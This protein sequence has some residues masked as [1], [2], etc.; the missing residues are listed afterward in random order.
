MNLKDRTERLYHISG[1]KLKFIKG[2]TDYRCCDKILFK[3][4]NRWKN[5][6]I[7]SV[8]IVD[9]SLEFTICKIVNNKSEYIYKIIEKDIRKPKNEEEWKEGETKEESKEEEKEERKE[10]E[11]MDE[12]KVEEKSRIFDV[13]EDVEAYLMYKGKEQWVK[14]KVHEYNPDNN[15]Y[16][17]QF[18]SVIRY[19]VDANLVREIKS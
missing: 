2:T 11:K 14:T 19:N 4:D 8:N 12:K 1:E 15:C 7:H 6:F 10:E 3:N 17:L 18:G 5:G 9:N 13:D 16:D